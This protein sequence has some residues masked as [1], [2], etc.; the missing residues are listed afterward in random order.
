MSD[1]SHRRPRTRRTAVLAAASVAVAGALS[2]LPLTM[3][4]HAAPDLAHAVL[5]ARDGWAASGKGTTGGSAA[6][7]SRVFT[8][9]TR[10]ELA[11][12]L[13]SGSRTEPRIIRV[14]GL[15]DANTDDDGRSLRCEDYAKG[16]GYS[17]ASYLKAYDPAVRGRSQV[18]SGAQESAR[19]AAQKK[20]AARIVFAVPANTTIVGVPG[21]GA[22]LTG[23]SLQVKNVDNVIIRNLA[24]ADVRDCFPQWDPTDGSDGNWNSSYDAV[25]L[26]GAT[27]VWADHNT[28]TDAPRFDSGNPRH[29][30]REYQVHDG[31]L[32]ITNAS[33]LV[34]VSYNRFADHDKT[35]LIGSSD[36][37]SKLRV[38]LHHNIFRGTVQRAPLARVGQVHLYNNLFDTTTR[39]GYAFSYSVSSRARAQVVAEY[40]HWTLP[41]DGKVSRLLTGDGTGALAGTGNLVNGRGAD[42]VAAYNAENPGKRIRPTVNWRPVLSAGLV[43]SAAALADS[44]GR[45]AGAGVLT[46]SGGPAGSAVPAP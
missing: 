12:A 17:L 35:M 3:S 32:D 1:P 27:H 31:S 2:A 4:A 39:N 38:T 30:G 26:R 28:F 25:S 8:V 34:T 37:D 21:T 16:T 36:K 24:F 6:V 7:A 40:N 11:K 13:S 9:S 33:D 5:P 19:T 42:L 43:T 22:G 23:G 29:F 14:K 46:A 20:Q 41:G 18:P 44:L 15:I 10:A 45:T